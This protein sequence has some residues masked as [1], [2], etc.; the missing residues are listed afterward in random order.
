MDPKELA[1]LR[2]D[3]QKAEAESKRWAAKVQ[4][5]YAAGQLTRARTTT[6]NA[7][8]SEA[9]ERRDELK[10]MLKAAEAA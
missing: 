3:Y 6:L 4:A 8:W 5:Y 7:R 10:K 2:K 9:A 1:A